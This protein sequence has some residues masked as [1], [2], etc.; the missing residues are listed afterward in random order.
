MIEWLIGASLLLLV[1]SHAY[2]TYSCFK[3]KPQISTSFGTF[4]ESL[5]H[6]KTDITTEVDNLSMVANAGVNLLDE[7]IQ[8][9]ADS[10]PQQTP[11]GSPMEVFLNALMSRNAMGPNNANTTEQ[12]WTVQTPNEDSPTTNP[13]DQHHEPR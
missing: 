13:N 7:L 4:C 10:L 2:L 6:H 5:S 11:T 8:V 12:E 1:A 9:L 3:I